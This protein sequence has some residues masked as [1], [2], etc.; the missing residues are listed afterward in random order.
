VG[1]RP[2]RPS[3]ASTCSCTKV[4]KR[5]HRKRKVRFLCWYAEC[6]GPSSDALLMFRQCSRLRSPPKPISTSSIDILRMPAIISASAVE[7]THVL[8][9]I[10]ADRIAGRKLAERHWIR[11]QGRNSADT[12]GKARRGS[13]CFQHS[14][15]SSCRLILIWNAGAIKITEYEKALMHQHEA[16]E[17]LAAAAV[18]KCL[19]PWQWLMAT[20]QS[21]SNASRRADY[22][23]PF[24]SMAL[25]HEF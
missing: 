25:L 11:A 18:G 5:S 8:S 1:C 13:R 23:L 14:H 20:L 22:P 4:A 10:N 12:R 19:K 17:K 2:T 21:R 15:R 7:I 16:R 3:R 24:C 6:S 9:T